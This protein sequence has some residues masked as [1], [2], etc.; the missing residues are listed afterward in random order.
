MTLF[1]SSSSVLRRR[2]HLF[3]PTSTFPDGDEEFRET[4][5]GQF[6]GLQPP[7]P[8]LVDTTTQVIRAAPKVS[9]EF[10]DFFQLKRGNN[11]NCAKALRLLSAFGEGRGA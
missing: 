11:I 10:R 1:P 5:A 7:P 8:L 6:E 2:P 4:Q 9:L 3:H